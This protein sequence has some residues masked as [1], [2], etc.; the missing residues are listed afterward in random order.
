MP[1]N[2][3]KIGSFSNKYKFKTS[4]FLSPEKLLLALLI[5]ILDSDKIKKGCVMSSTLIYFKCY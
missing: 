4:P 2:L 1:L 5:L 3:S